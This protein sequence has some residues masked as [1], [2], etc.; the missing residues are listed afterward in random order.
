MSSTEALLEIGIV[1]IKDDDGKHKS[2]KRKKQDNQGDGPPRDE[3]YGMMK[4][5]ERELEFLS[6][7]E[8]FIK[9]E[10]K[11]LRREIIRAREEIKRIQ[12]VPLAVGSFS[13][14]IDA[15]HAIITHGGETRLVRILST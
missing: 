1:D 13:E 14:V 7:Q 9:E 2:K 4:Q 5:H 12:S 15:D 10:M 8:E 6:I 3:P 11:N